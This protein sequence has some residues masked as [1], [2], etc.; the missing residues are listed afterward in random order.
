[1]PHPA[2]S[3]PPLL[4]CCPESATLSDVKLLPY[5]LQAERR[6]IPLWSQDGTCFKIVS[7][8]TSTSY[9]WKTQAPT[10]VELICLRCLCQTCLLC[11]L[12]MLAFCKVLLLGYSCHCHL[13]G[14]FIPKG[15]PDLLFSYSQRTT[16]E[17]TL[18]AVT[19]RQIAEVRLRNPSQPPKCTR[20]NINVE[21]EEDEAT[22]DRFGK[23]GSH[24]RRKK[25][26]WKMMHWWWL[27]GEE[28]THLHHLLWSFEERL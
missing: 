18:R 8:W 22:I 25:K 10:T 15:K 28:H 9:I 26:L 1:M 7:S 2:S 21:R 4:A 16:S 19:V 5:E 11:M 24:A 17:Q 13:I 12:H 3:T 20:S 23:G 27:P 6:F 14:L